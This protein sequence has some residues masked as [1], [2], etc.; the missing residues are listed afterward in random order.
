MKLTPFIVKNI[1]APHGITDISHA[2]MT[3]RNKELF[4]LNLFNVGLA[5]TIVTPFSLSNHYDVI[6][7]IATIIHFKNDFSNIKIKN[8]VF[9]KYISSA[10]FIA[11]CLLINKV[12]PYNLGYDILLGYMTIIHVP[13][14]YR[15]NWFHIKK[16]LVLNFLIMMFTIAFF[17][18]ISDSFPELMDNIYMINAGKAIIISHIFYQEKY[19]KNNQSV[20]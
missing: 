16:D 12:I 15:E 5:E 3:N 2:L 18:G 9:P 11:I 17:N 7:F 20:F 4:L 10:L 19:I 13:N 6:F 1:I 8:F 14:H